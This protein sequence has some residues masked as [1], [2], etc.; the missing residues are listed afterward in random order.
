MQDEHQLL[1]NR[2]RAYLR[3]LLGDAGRADRVLAAFLEHLLASGQHPMGLA[4][5]LTWL[6]RWFPYQLWHSTQDRT[7]PEAQRLL[8]W[9]LSGF[10]FRERALIILSGL[11]EVGPED[12]HLILGLDDDEA[13]AILHDAEHRIA[14]SSVIVMSS[15]AFVALDVAMILEDLGIRRVRTTPHLR[16]LRALAASERPIAVVADTAGG[17]SPACIQS[18]LE[19]APS[20]RI[21][22]VILDA[23]GR[24]AH[25][26]IAL[27]KPFTARALH[28][29]L[30]T[31]IGA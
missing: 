23:R 29:A 12:A 7:L 20:R 13:A 21:P 3:L 10:T 27:R 1:W 17:L 4:G 31:A 16:E 5:V 11:P 8:A 26:G 22:S 2:V 28:Q 24:C 18:V 15:Q 30:L 19:P 6:H 9:Y 25:G 14:E